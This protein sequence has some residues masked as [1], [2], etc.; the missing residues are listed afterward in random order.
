MSTRAPDAAS[1]AGRTRAARGRPALWRA[2]L[3]RAGLLAA[4]GA[5]AVVLFCLPGGVRAERPAVA[6]E[7]IVVYKAARRMDLRKDGAVVA[8]YRIALGANP[9]G[10]KVFVGD[11]RTPEGAYFISARNPDSRFY[12]SL[13]I[14]YPSEEDRDL[15]GRFGISAGGDIMIHGQPNRPRRSHDPRT[16]WTDGC[17]AVD[18]R[19]MDEIWSSVA[20]GTPIRILP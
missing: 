1:P 8:R 6:V 13:R 14:S 11:G 5:L 7:E 16:D 19:D 18:N 10:R 15:A 2:G 12:R 4:L 17:I 3:W 20:V 9:E